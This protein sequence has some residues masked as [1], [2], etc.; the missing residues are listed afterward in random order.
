MNHEHNR[1]VFY[2]VE[3]LLKVQLPEQ[4]FLFGDWFEEGMPVLISAPTKCGK[5]FLG[6]T[7]MYN[8]SLGIPAFGWTTPEGGAPVAI[9]DGEMRPRTIQ[10]RL[11]MMCRSCGDRSGKLIV[12]S[13]ESYTDRGVPFPDFHDPKQVSAMFDLITE[14]LGTAPK[15]ILFD[16][17]NC[18]FTGGDENSPLFWHPVESVS[19]ECK[20]R[21]IAAIF[22][23]HNP[24]SSPDAPAGSSKAER[25]PE[26]VI[27]LQKIGEAAGKEV[28]FNLKFRH[29]RDLSDTAT[30]ISAR[31]VTD[32]DDIQRWELGP[33]IEQM[34]SIC[35]NDSRREQ[36]LALE[37]KSL[38]EIERIT[39]IPKSTVAELRKC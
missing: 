22:V 32:E 35:G 38:R 20:Q 10:R 19:R 36:V 31:L 11:A 15:A 24:K 33:Y 7:M 1:P 28:Y 30:N 6:Y 23:H 34:Q 16:N 2:T 12:I 21:K 17:L 13:R 4:R 14:K 9:V 8:L 26:A 37:G 29:L 18:L 3:E 25:I 5:S 39:G 27:V